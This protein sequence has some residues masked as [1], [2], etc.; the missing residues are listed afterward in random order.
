MPYCGV[1]DLYMEACGTQNSTHAN[2]KSRISPARS[3]K[4]LG[5]VKNYGAVIALAGFFFGDSIKSMI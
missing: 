3:L 1:L 4:Y 5:N 2:I